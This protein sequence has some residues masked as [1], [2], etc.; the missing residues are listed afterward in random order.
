MGN[1]AVTLYRYSISGNTWTTLAPGVARAGA[2]VAGTVAAWVQD[3]DGTNWANRSDIRDSRY[4]F[5][6]PWRRRRA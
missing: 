2:P 4:I 5:S 3:S 6:F 1:N